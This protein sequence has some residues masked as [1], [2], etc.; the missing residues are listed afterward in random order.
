MHLLRGASPPRG[1]FFAAARLAVVVTSPWRS[2]PNMS[3]RSSAEAACGA[4]RLPQ[5]LPEALCGLQPVTSE[6]NSK[7]F[8][9]SV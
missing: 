7:I 5:A 3:L 6:F 4:S 9:N 1:I 8:R 2:S